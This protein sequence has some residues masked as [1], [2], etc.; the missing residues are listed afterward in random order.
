LLKDAVLAPKD[1]SAFKFYWTGQLQDDYGK[2]W[3]NAGQDQFQQYASNIGATTS[4]ARPPSNVRMASY[5]D[6]RQNQGLPIP[7]AAPYP[8]GHNKSG[9]HLDHLRNLEENGGL[10]LPPGKN[11]KASTF[12]GNIS[13]QTSDATMDE[14][15]TTAQGLVNGAGKAQMAPFEGT[16]DVP[17]DV[18]RKVTGDLKR[19]KGKLPPEVQK[20]LLPMDVQSAAWAEF[21]GDPSY[22]RPLLGHVSDRI[23][24]TARVTGLPVDVVKD[25]FLRKI[26]P[27][28]SMGG[29]GL[30]GYGSDGE[31]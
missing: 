25:L 8:Y 29:I 13:G 21:G 7:T 27:P 26:I 11:P 17:V 18:F 16:Y 23:N 6:V 30:L 4:G 3:G 1:P 15:M 12:S 20:G 19:T 28:L 5:Y 14:V 10:L 31:Q 24:V 22:M 9:T 2:V